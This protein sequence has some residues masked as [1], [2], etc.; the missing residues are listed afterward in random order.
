G[1]EEVCMSE[2]PPRLSLKEVWASVGRLQSAGERWVMNLWDDGASLL[3]RQPLE[4]AERALRDLDAQRRQLLATLEEQANRLFAR[5]A[6]RVNAASRADLANLSQRITT[7]EQ[8]L[9][10]LGRER[11]IPYGPSGP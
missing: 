9:E 6:K 1:K 11:F 2:S 8:R 7:L 10:A 5:M 4:R 3:S